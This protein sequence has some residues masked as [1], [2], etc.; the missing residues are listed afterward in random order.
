MALCE[1]LADEAL[2]GGGAAGVIRLGPGPDVA[3]VSSL[4]VRASDGQSVFTPPGQERYTTA[5]WLDLEEYLVAQARREVPQLVTAG[6]AAATLA[7]TNLDEAQREVAAGLL[8]ARTATSVLVAPAG[9]GKTHTVAAFA[10]AWTAWTGRRVIGLTASTNASRVMR[11]DGLATEGLAEAYNIAQFL[12]RLEDGGSRGAMRIARDDVLVIDEASQVSTTDL[13]AIQAVASAAGA[14][15]VLTGD[16]A[17][18]GAVEAGGMMRLIASDLG[19]WELAEV[20]RFDAEWERL[21]SLQLR[22]G[23]RAALRAY[24]ARGRIRGGPQPEAEAEAVALYLADYLLGRDVLLLAGTNEEAARLAGQVRE[25]L[26]RLGRV[27]QRLEVVLA[28]GNGAARGDLVRARLNT[29]I[30]AAGGPLSNRDTLRLMGWTGQGEARVAIVQRQLSGGG[31]SRDFPVPAD[32]LRR[33][34]ELAY[35]ANVYVAQGRTVD[36]AHLYVSP[37]LTRESLYVG[38]TRGREAN[39][40]HVVTGPAQ[41]RGQEPMAQAEPEAV[42]AEILDR[43]GSTRTATEAM[44]EAQA[45]VTDTRHLFT[46]WSAA[47]RAEAYAAIDAGLQNRLSAAEYAR[48]EREPQ[49]P[50]LQRQVLAATLSGVSLDEALD[51]ATGGD[52]RGARS[53]AAVMHGRIKAAGVDRAGQGQTVTWAERTPAAAR[54]GVGGALAVAMDDR[55]RHLGAELWER[56]EPWLAQYLGSP[57]PVTASP[58]LIQDW[59]MRAGIAASYREAAGL[60]DPDVAFGPAP[61]GVPELAEAY[62]A[63]LVAL[64]VPDVEAQVRGMTRGELERD[65]A[66]YARFQATAPPEPSRELR[67]VSLAAADARAHTVHLDAEGH[68]QAAEMRERQADAANVQATELEGQLEAYQAWEEATAPTRELAERASAELARRDAAER[69]EAGAGRRPEPVPEPEAEGQA[70]GSS[71]AQI[72][73]DHGKTGARTPESAAEAEPRQLAPPEPARQ[74]ALDRARVALESVQDELTAQ[75]ERETSREAQTASDEAEAALAAT[76]AP[77]AWIPGPNTPSWGGPGARMG[78]PAPA[79]EVAEPAARHV[80]CRQAARVCGALSLTSRS[81]TASASARARSLSPWAMRR[82][83]E[84][85]ETV[86][87][88]E[89]ARSSPSEPVAHRARMRSAVQKSR[90]SMARMR[91]WAAMASVSLVGLLARGLRSG[92]RLG[93]HAAS[94][95]WPSVSCWLSGPATP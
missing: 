44:R 63:A 15:I 35:A 27:P 86:T 87:A 91:A 52:M 47:T 78:E 46:M 49:R 73:E 61:Q 80:R 77:S 14:R 4:G 70:V 60:V 54:A 74:A 9:A 26:V 62:A 23:E 29:H 22:R 72:L 30:D 37:T 65:V 51:V 41:V 32:Y 3:D 25:R 5:A 48:Y 94:P 53:I 50:V 76:S 43:V 75:A 90:A 64:E 83:T 42:L 19:H 11:G 2:A 34:T 82:M 28:D 79:A 24:D 88:A 7:G 55:A 31:W 36:A 21:A 33:S 56:P 68:A 85:A 92:Q 69:Q 59:Q 40:A 58:A 39:T 89:N 81:S 16:T 67:A 20:R 17:Q 45:F 66:H 1:E 10:R 18:L 12:G 6:Q 71:A 38:M 95:P 8:T 57:P 84:Q 13:A 93:C